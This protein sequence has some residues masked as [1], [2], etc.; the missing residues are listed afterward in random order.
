MSLDL[1]IEGV[2]GDFTL[3]AQVIIT[4]PT[5][6]AMTIYNYRLVEY[7]GY[8]F[9]QD[10]VKGD[11]KNLEAIFKFPTPTNLTDLRFFLV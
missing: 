9:G 11:R 4:M 3:T 5:M 6:L 1:S 7:V 8:V 2:Q 10:D